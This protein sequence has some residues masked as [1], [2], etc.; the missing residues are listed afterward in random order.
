MRVKVVGIALRHSGKRFEIGEVLD[1]AEHPDLAEVVA[2][3]LRALTAEEVHGDAAMP[4]DLAQA[5]A[6]LNDAALA[7]SAALAA[8]LDVVEQ[9]PAGYPQMFLDGLDQAS[10][11]EPA[12]AVSVR[13]EAV[14]TLAAQ[15]RH[16]A[17]EQ[18]APAMQAASDAAADDGPTA[19][20]TQ[21]SEAPEAEATGSDTVTVAQPGAN[22]EGGDTPSADGAG[23]PPA[24]NDAP[25]PEGGV[26][27]DAGA[28]PAAP[29]EPAAAPKPARSKRKSA[30]KGAD[31]A[32]AGGDD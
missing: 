24:P 23:A 12:A 1:L 15:E 2:E 26:D 27:G 31:Q 10:A 3:R 5:L 19:A 6:T 17:I 11:A 7:L 32:K 16:D 22:S 30:P 9:G 28:A 4:A 21:N 20:S 8:A 25:Q 14:R 13:L 18:V 29:A